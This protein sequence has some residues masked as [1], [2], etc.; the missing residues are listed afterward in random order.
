[1]DEFR[2]ISC[3]TFFIESYYELTVSKFKNISYFIL[4]CPFYLKILCGVITMNF[5]FIL[6]EIGYFNK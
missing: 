6:L 5:S 4:L 1:M 2:N 3:V